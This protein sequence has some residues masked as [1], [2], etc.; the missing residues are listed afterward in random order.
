DRARRQDAELLR[1]HGLV[2][3]RAD[4]GLRPAHFP[5]RRPV[6]AVVL[7]VVLAFALALAERAAPPA[8]AG[9]GFGAGS[10]AIASISNRAPGRASCEMPTAVLA[11][12]GIAKN[13][14][15]ISR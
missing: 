5:L 2:V 15:R 7:A 8:L 12:R 6:L 14:S 9:A 11:G 3:R 13:L 10:T 4:P 1:L